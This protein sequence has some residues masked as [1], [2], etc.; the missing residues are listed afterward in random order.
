MSAIVKEKCAHLCANKESVFGKA[1]DMMPNESFVDHFVKAV[2]AETGHD[3]VAEIDIEPGEQDLANW[4]ASIRNDEVWRGNVPYAT[5]GCD[6]FYS[7]LTDIYIENLCEAEYNVCNNIIEKL[8]HSLEQASANTVADF[9]EEHADALHEELRYNIVETSLSIEKKR[10]KCN[11]VL[12]HKGEGNS[13]FG[14]IREMI[15][16]LMDRVPDDECMMN[17]ALTWLVHQQGYSMADVVA[18]FG[19]ENATESAFIKSVCEE[20]ENCDNVMNAVTICFSVTADDFDGLVDGAGKNLK[21]SKNA[22]IGL[23]APWVGGGSTMEIVLEKD[24]ILPQ[25]MINQIQIEGAK[26]R[27]YSVDDVFGMSGSFWKPGCLSWTDEPAYILSPETVADDV[28]NILALSEN[29][30]SVALAG[31][32]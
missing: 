8:K 25:S 23:F 19:T 6:S 32:K 22:N 5:Q 31:P 21:I 13:D 12:G 18:Q 7:F 24:I 2:I 14:A 28:N 16:L 10:F 11:L 30:E 20:M 27:E 4:L 17:N 29:K 26:N 9:V 3:G 15:D 1:A